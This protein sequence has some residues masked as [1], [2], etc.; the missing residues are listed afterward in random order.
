MNIIQMDG[1]LGAIWAM[2]ARGPAP[3]TIR[4]RIARGARA[5]AAGGIV[6]V[7]LAMASGIATGQSIAGTD[8]ALIAVIPQPTKVTARPGEFRM[9]RATII[10]SDPA[11]APVARQLARYLEPATGFTFVVRTTGAP[12]AGSITLRRSPALAR[13]GAEG[14]TLTVSRTGVAMRAPEAAGLFYA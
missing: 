2:A 11:S 9:T 12:P 5:A 4:Y 8:S 1:A 3:S 10:W 6:A 7:A 14:Y 13:L